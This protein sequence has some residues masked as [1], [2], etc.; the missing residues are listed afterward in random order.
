MHQAH[1]LLL[2]GFGLSTDGFLPT[3]YAEIQA[4]SGRTLTLDA[5]ASDSGDNAHCANFCSPSNSF[6]SKEHVGHIWVNAPFSQLAS[7]LQHYL[8]CK[9]LSPENISA[10]I[11]V[12]GYLLPMCKPLLSGMCL[13]KKFSKGAAIFEQSLRKGRAATTPGVSWP[14]YIY[15]DVPDEGSTA[16]TRD[17]LCTSCIMLQLCLL[18]KALILQLTRVLP[19]SLKGAFGETMD[20]D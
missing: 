20:E 10:C 9:Q 11:L 5:A 18:H 6:M 15:T 13:L 19:C 8:H 12:P 17:S 7:F 16:L 3:A 4:L 14:V 2:T 1:L